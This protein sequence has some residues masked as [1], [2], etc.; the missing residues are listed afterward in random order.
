MSNV[1]DR[2]PANAPQPAALVDA[3]EGIIDT[4]LAHMKPKAAARAKA[5][6]TAF[7]ARLERDPATGLPHNVRR[8][9]DHG[10]AGAV[11]AQER[12]A[13][14]AAMRFLIGECF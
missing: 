14:A 2:K 3:A 5:D 8:I 7:V 10:Y 1:L 6:L 12:A 4:L 9:R 13:R 11:D